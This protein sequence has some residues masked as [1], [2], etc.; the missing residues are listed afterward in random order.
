LVKKKKRRTQRRE[1]GGKNTKGKG[2][3]GS[4]TV[5]GGDAP[6]RK[7]GQS[8]RERRDFREPLSSGRGKI[9]LVNR[10]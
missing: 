7:R 5:Q 3:E 8:G 4:P 1:R 10:G 9:I 2:N 6:Q